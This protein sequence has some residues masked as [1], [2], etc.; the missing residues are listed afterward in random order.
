MGRSAVAKKSI[1][2]ER[3]KKALDTSG[4]SQA[5]LCEEIGMSRSA[6]SG[7]LRSDFIPKQDRLQK[8]AQILNV[9]P[10][11]LMGSDDSSEIKIEKKPEK[12]KAVDKCKETPK[13]TE[14]AAKNLNFVPVIDVDKVNSDSLSTVSQNPDKFN[15]RLPYCLTF[16]GNSQ[17]IVGIRLNSAN[18]HINTCMMPYLLPNDVI[19]VD[20][21]AKPKPGDMILVDNLID[22]GVFCIYA[23]ED[24][25]YF[26]FPVDTQMAEFMHSRCKI[27]AVVKGVFRAVQPV[28]SKYD[29][30]E[31]TNT[32]SMA[33]SRNADGS[34]ELSEPPSSE[35]LETIEKIKDYD[36]Y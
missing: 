34:G 24:K 31:P 11:W 1:F 12:E 17:N 2:T 23:S 22:P 30:G 14:K 35:T 21:K 6:L 10:D 9:S 7:Y 4:V 8:M 16:T 3:L 29:W 5:K 36:G 26:R 18:S 33:I 15:K 20:T 32:N 13:E 25:P 19:F 28:P 27:L